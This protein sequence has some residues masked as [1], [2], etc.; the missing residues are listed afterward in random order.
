[1]FCNEWARSVFVRSSTAANLPVKNHKM[2]KVRFYQEEVTSESAS[3]APF[4]LN[5]PAYALAPFFSLPLCWRSS[6]AAEM[7]RNPALFTVYYCETKRAALP[8]SMPQHQALHQSKLHAG[9]ET[10]LM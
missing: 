9:E 7:E 3:P 5:P 2:L 10:N 4:L 8:I 6:A 1:M